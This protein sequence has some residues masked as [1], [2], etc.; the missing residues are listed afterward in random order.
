MKQCTQSFVQCLVNE[1]VSS[2]VV[3][4]VVGQRDNAYS[5]RLVR[6]VRKESWG[7]RA[8]WEYN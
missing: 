3:M 4:V 2:T 7:D 1:Y 8:P 6:G 5:K